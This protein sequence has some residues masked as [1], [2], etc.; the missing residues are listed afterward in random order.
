MGYLIASELRDQVF[1]WLANQ[2]QQRP[3]WMPTPV[4]DD[5][6]VVAPLSELDLKEA[7]SRVR[8]LWLEAGVDLKILLVNSCG[9]VRPFGNWN[10]KL[11]K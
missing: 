11:V 8:G 6:L 3:L 5:R 2:P 10:H 7:D 1:I 9:P 4:S